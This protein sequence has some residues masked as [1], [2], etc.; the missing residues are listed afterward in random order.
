MKRILLVWI[1][2][3][4]LYAC[5]PVSAASAAEAKV[6]VYETGVT[7]YQYVNTYDEVVSD[8]FSAVFVEVDG[9]IKIPA[10]SLKRMGGIL[11]HTS[12]AGGKVTITDHQKSM[13]YEMKIGS[14]KVTVLNKDK[15]K[16]SEF[17]LSKEVTVHLVGDYPCYPL[18]F[19]EKIGY[20]AEFDGKRTI[21]VDL[22]LKKAEENKE[23]SKL[24]P[25]SVGSKYG[26]MNTAGKV[27][28]EAEYDGALPF[29]E[30]LAAVKADGKW[31]YIDETGKMA[32]LPQ[33]DTISAFEEGIAVVGQYVDGELKMGYLQ[34]SGK[35]L[36]A[37]DFNYALPFSEGY[38]AATY[39]KSFFYMNQDGIY[40]LY[41]DNDDA[42]PFSDGLA[43]I[44]RKNSY[45][46]INKRGEEV[47]SLQYEDAGDFNEGLA[48]VK[49]DG[50]WGYIDKNGETVIPYRYDHA[51]SF[52]DGLAVVRTGKLYG[53][54][55]KT[56]KTTV[57]SKFDMIGTGH[58]GYWPAQSAN[59]WGFIDVK[60][61]WV[62]GPEYEFAYGAASGLFYLQ[63]ESRSYYVDSQGNEVVPRDANGNEYVRI[64][65]AGKAIEVNGKLLELN[66]LPS[67]IEGVTYVPAQSVLESVGMD[68]E[69]DAESLTLTAK[70]PGLSIDLQADKAVAQ[71]NGKEVELAAASFIWEDVLYV[72][73]SF[74]KGNVVALLDVTE[75]APV[76][77]TE[78]GMEQAWDDFAQWAES[79]E[80]ADL[81]T[82][83]EMA[84]QIEE[85]FNAVEAEY[86]AIFQSE[87]N[88]DA[89]YLEYAVLLGELAQM[90][91]QE[92]LWAESAAMAKKVGQ[93]NART[94]TYYHLYAADQR[95]V[96]AEKTEVYRKAAEADPYLL[97]NH[98]LTN[99]TYYEAGIAFGEMKGMSS[100]AV[101]SLKL[102]AAYGTEEEQQEAKALLDEKYGASME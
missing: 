96:G 41:P 47:I 88:N 3:V 6:K 44:G 101:Y 94:A 48:A 68:A 98:A 36:K 27:V 62:I 9:S 38:G 100:F 8:Y 67:V 14:S 55:D 95:L 89:A 51:G 84:A 92:E 77:L 50:K 70:R 102:A 25:F 10:F 85:H 20:K 57:P 46:Y 75:Y 72:P 45:G 11:S 81:E 87:P 29:A 73:A 66:H 39:G 86:A 15:I 19:F 26:Y 40:V 52:E 93:I 63:S 60:G 99:G 22:S 24:V 42:G 18:D 76:D 43:K 37:P 53:L 65:T 2:S 83:L 33:Y 28:I 13:T 64:W 61:N 74:L 54:I 35:L 23:D 58:N 56:G 80:N 7:A 1:A 49:Q 34:Q 71:V 59:Q 16:Q 90:F 69:W 32:I 5:W 4:M 30:K 97:L 79:F 12:G 17:T 91:E 31:G 21:N 82:Q 78:M